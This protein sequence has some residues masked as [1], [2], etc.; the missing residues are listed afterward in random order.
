MPKVPFFA[1]FVCLCPS[2]FVIVCFSHL[3]SPYERF[4]FFFFQRVNAF[5]CQSVL[6]TTLAYLVEKTEGYRISKGCF[7]TKNFK[8]LSR[9]LI[10]Q[11]PKQIRTKKTGRGLQENTEDKKKEKKEIKCRNLN[12]KRKRKRT[13]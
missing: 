7:S 11:P 8:K 6:K 13:G 10:W 5:F 4:P 12:K 3:T 2:G 1:F 9:P